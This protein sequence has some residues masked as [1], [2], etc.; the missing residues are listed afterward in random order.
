MKPIKQL[1]LIVSGVSLYFILTAAPASAHHAFASEYDASKPVMIRGTVTKLEWINP[2]AWIYI[3]AK[4]TDGRVDQWMIE[5][6]GPNALASRGYTRDFLKLGMEVVVNGYLSKSGGFRMNARDLTVPGSQPFFIGSTGTG[7]PYDDVA[8]T[9]NLQNAANDLRTARTQVAGAWWMNTPL[10]QRLGIT[11]EQQ[12]KIEKTFENHL[13][14]IL[15]TTASLEKEE[16]QLARLMDSDPI[17]QNA[18]YTQIDRVIQA[19]SEVERIN[20]VMTVE[21]RQYLTRTQWEQL[22][23]TNLTTGATGRGGRTAV[24]VPPPPGGRGRGQ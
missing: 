16:A 9:Q 24:P 21:M 18:V 6:A 20:S 23:R 2:H 22:P 8:A 3:D 4:R 5:A 7:A 13:Q 10:M 15:S 1:S 11:D 17:D 19:R 14:S 12:S